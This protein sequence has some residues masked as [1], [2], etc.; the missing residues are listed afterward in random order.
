MKQ[1]FSILAA[2][3]LMLL[4]YGFYQGMYV[5]PTEV[6]MG[7]IYRIFFWHVPINISAE[8]FPYVNMIASIAFLFYRRSKPELALKLD[9]LAV[10]SAEV[11]VLYVGLGLI[12]GMLWARPVWGIWWTWDARL[13]TFLLLFLL[14]VSYLLVRR[15]SSSG[16]NRTVAAVLSVFA[17]VD[18]PIVFMSIR[19]WRTQHPSPVLTGEGKLDQSMWPALLWNMLAWFLWGVALVWARYAL[20]RREQRI[21]QQVALRAVEA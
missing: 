20:T 8:I 12:S 10:A 18:V 14:Y 6:T 1:L 5:A 17:G 3:S 19:W 9:A 2:V 4:C 16:S 7:P 21:E 11:T 15:F 13:T